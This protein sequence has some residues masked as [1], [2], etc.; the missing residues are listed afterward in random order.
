[1]TFD[2]DLNLGYPL[3]YGR[4]LLRLSVSKIALRKTTNQI[5]MKLFQ[6]CDFG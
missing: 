4:F 2:L 6:R 5:C 1:M 3:I